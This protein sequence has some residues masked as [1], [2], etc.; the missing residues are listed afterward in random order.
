MDK[1]D[2]I[3]ANV[4]WRFLDVRGWVGLEVWASNADNSFVGPTHQHTMMGKALHAACVSSRVNDRFQESVCLVLEL[5]RAGVVHGTKWGGPDAE[6]FSGGP[7]FGTDEEQSSMLLIM[8][9]L[10]VLPLGFRVSDAHGRCAWAKRTGDADDSHNNG[11]ARYLASCWSST[12]LFVPSASHCGNCSR[13][14]LCTL[15]SPA[16]PGGTAMISWT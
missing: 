9:V 16:T 10:S 7:S 14:R 6:P 3:V 11:S 13:P 15:F 2:E 4:L 1:K 5:L 8:R 12:R